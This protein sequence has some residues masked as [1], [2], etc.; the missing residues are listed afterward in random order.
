MPPNK[1]QLTPTYHSWADVV[2]RFQAGHYGGHLGYLNGTNLAIL[3]LHVNPMPPTKVGLNPTYRSGADMIW[4]FSKLATLEAILDITTELFWQFWISMLLWCLPSSFSSIQLTVWEMLF[5]D[6][7]DGWHGSQL[8]YQ[9]NDFSNSK[10]PC[11]PNA[12]Q[13][14][15]G[16]GSTP[17][18]PSWIAKWFKQVWIRV[19]LM[20]SIKF[21]LNP[22]YGSGGNVVWRYQN[23]TILVIL[24]LYLAPMPPI[25]FWLNP[26]KGLG[27]DVIW[28]FSR[29][30]HGSHLGYQNWMI[31]AILNLYNAPMPPIKFW[32]NLTYGMGGDVVWRI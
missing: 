11:G 27:G 2:S 17:S 23:G 10:L 1:F 24:N 14:N 3:N 26:T 8:E 28:K 29:G 4:R 21:R 20:L 15:L 22:T 7:Q 9:N 30:G 13:S 31:L 25:K 5:E 12:S 19:A 6:F 32:L 16:F 18:L